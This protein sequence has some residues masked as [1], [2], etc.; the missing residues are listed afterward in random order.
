MTRKSINLLL[1]GLIGCSVAYVSPISEMALLIG[2]PPSE[3]KTRL[4]PAHR[5]CFGAP[6][7]EEFI[8]GRF[9]MRRN[10]VLKTLLPGL[11]AILCLAVLS[12]FVFPLQA[13]V[14][15]KVLH[16]FNGQQGYWPDGVIIGPDGSIYGAT[17]WGGG[18]G[19]GGCGTVYKLAANTEGRWQETEVHY[20]NHDRDGCFPNENLIL[21]S[22]GNLYGTIQELGGTTGAVVELSPTESGG[23]HQST[24]YGFNSAQGIFPEAGVIRDTAGNLYGTIWGDG[25][26]GAG[27]VFELTPQTDGSWTETTLHFFD[28]TDGNQLNDTLI[29]DAFW[30]SLRHGARRRVSQSGDRLGTVTTVGRQ[31]ELHHPLQ[32]HW[33]SRRRYSLDARWKSNF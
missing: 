27:S 23:W 22:A 28:N 31:L 19:N 10:R 2:H 5:F 30:Q 4:S 12:F 6:D 9:S 11:K 24:I 20:F 13:A 16:H 1:F 32:F 14:R 21:D 15:S 18:S 8:F 25:A 33:Q 3:A 7:E 26:Y 29:M 17:V